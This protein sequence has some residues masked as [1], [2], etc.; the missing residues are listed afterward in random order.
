MVLKPVPL[1]TAKSL[2]NSTKQA[3]PVFRAVKNLI[4]THFLS[5]KKGLE[6]V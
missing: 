5:S 2:I 4:E 6:W 1:R 3:A